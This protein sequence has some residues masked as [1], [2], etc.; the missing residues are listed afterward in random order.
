MKQLHFKVG[1][2]PGL[3]ICLSSF[4]PGRPFPSPLLKGVTYSVTPSKVV[5]YRFCRGTVFRRAPALRLCQ[6]GAFLFVL[7]LHDVARL[8]AE[9]FTQALK[10][11]G[12]YMTLAL[13]HFL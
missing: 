11:A 12:I 5:F 2:S 13:T 9:V 4:P 3:R 1:V 10:R 8:A 7:V 6:G